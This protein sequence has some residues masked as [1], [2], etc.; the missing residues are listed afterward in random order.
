MLSILKSQPNLN[1]QLVAVA[2]YSC[3]HLG[4]SEIDLWSGLIEMQWCIQDVIRRKNDYNHVQR[5]VLK[6]NED[7]E[8]NRVIRWFHQS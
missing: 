8:N 2:V 4:P 1:S 6:T 5:A 7:E 3:I